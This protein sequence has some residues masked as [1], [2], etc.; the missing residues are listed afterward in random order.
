MYYSRLRPQT[1]DTVLPPALN[2]NKVHKTEFG[3]YSCVSPE[4]TVAKLEAPKEFIMGEKVCG[5]I[6]Y[7]S[8]P[9][10]AKRETLCSH[11]ASLLL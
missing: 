4:L 3:D 1:R 5:Q 9:S 10:P 8:P 7:C 6:P 2:N 11:Q